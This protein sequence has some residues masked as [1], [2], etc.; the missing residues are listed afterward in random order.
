[1]FLQTYGLGA[2]DH[3]E[4]KLDSLQPRRAAQ[5]RMMSTIAART[6]KFCGDDSRLS[7]RRKTKQSGSNR[8]D[9]DVYYVVGESLTGATGTYVPGGGILHLL[10]GNDQAAV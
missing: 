8:E 1:M 2:S 3:S 7:R 4:Q 10:S 9:R 6:M 5:Y